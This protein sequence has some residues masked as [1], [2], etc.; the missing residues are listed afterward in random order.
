MNKGDWHIDVPNV[1]SPHFQTSFHIQSCN[2]ICLSPQIWSSPHI[3]LSPHIWSSPHQAHKFVLTLVSQ[4]QMCTVASW[5]MIMISMTLIPNHPLTSPHIQSSPYIWWMQI[6]LPNP[7]MQ[8][9]WIT[10]VLIWILIFREK[11]C[12][13]KTIWKSY[14]NIYIKKRFFTHLTKSLKK[15]EFF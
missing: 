4:S 9:S 5:P 13:L 11:I 12:L 14:F 1:C 15:Q 7:T 8:P 6:R 2:H 3:Q 10:R